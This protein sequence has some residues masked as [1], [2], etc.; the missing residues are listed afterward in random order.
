MDAESGARN[1]RKL[2]N[3]IVNFSPC[4]RGI[5]L[6]FKLMIFQDVGKNVIA[7][8]PEDRICEGPLD[9]PKTPADFV[10]DLID[11]VADRAGNPFT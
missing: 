5:R 9:Q 2:H 3:R 1:W 8:R 7:H 11:T 4:L 6:H 10:V